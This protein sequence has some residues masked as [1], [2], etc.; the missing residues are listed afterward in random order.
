MMIQFHDMER[1]A[2]HQLRLPRAQSNM[3]LNSSRDGTSTA[4]LGSLCQ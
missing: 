4:S 3:A 2:T 1:V